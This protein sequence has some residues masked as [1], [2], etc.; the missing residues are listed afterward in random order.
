MATRITRISH[1]RCTFRS[2]F[3]SARAVRKSHRAAGDGVQA[4]FVE[5]ADD[6]THIRLKNRSNSTNS[7]GLN[8]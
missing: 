5:S 7:G 6:V 8:A 2:R 1:L 4:G 3:S